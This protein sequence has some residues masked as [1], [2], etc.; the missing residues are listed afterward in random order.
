MGFN[1]AS[2][3]TDLRFE[4]SAGNVGVEICGRGGLRAGVLAACPGAAAT[5][6]TGARETAAA[7][8]DPSPA[9][10]CKFFCGVAASAATIP[11]HDLGVSVP[12]LLMNCGIDFARGVDTVRCELKIVFEQHLL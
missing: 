1:A 7:Q 4:R 9:W 5:T 12:E 6:G 2:I 3:A 11:A 8:T 10:R